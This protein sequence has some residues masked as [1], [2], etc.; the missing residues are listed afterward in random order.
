MNRNKTA[1]LVLMATLASLPMTAVADSGFFIG[2]SIGAATL[3]EDFEGLGLDTDS[4]S[5]GFNAGWR[6]SDLF[7]LEAGYH[8]FGKFEETLDVGGLLSDVTVEADGFTVGFAAS[9]PLGGTTSLFGRAG[10]FF[11]D[12]D[13]AI[14][15]FNLARPE[16]NNLYYGAG[17]DVTIS[18]RLSLIGDWTRYELEKTESDVISIGFRYRF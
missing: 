1:K 16:D 18:A 7:A 14:N 2:G 15:D 5:F 8:N 9:I 6:F 4:T 17:A 10:A 12:A 3:D 13:T 11:W